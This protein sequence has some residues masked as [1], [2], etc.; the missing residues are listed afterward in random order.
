M[1][2]ALAIAVALVL[3]APAQARAPLTQARA[4]NAAE[5]FVNDQVEDLDVALGD[6][7]TIARADLDPCEV[8]SSRRAEC[9]GTFTYSDG[10]ACDF[11]LTVRTTRRDRLTTDSEITWCDD[12]EATG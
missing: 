9:D 5:A 10:V 12:D 8:L 3:A 4:D 7:A 6:D 11:F 2:I 1:K